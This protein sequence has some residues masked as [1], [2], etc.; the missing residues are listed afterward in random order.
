VSRFW[1]YKFWLF[2][3]FQFLIWL[4][5]VERMPWDDDSENVAECI[6]I[7][8]SKG[9]KDSLLIDGKVEPFEVGAR[10]QVRLK[11]FHAL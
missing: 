10:L 2:H 9:Q 4:F 5:T 3:D 11:L 7:V 1:G 6:S 8:R